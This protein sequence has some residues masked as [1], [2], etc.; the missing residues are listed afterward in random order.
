MGT[1]YIWIGINVDEQ[2]RSFRKRLDS[3]EEELDINKSDVT[4]PFHISLKM[5]FLL[6]EN[7]VDDVVNDIVTYYQSLKSFQLSVKGI[8]CYENIIWIRMQETNQINKISDDLNEML[9]SQFGV[10]LHEYDG[11][12][13]FHSTLFMNDDVGKC[14]RIYEA[15][16]EDYLPETLTAERF[17]LCLSD[18]GEPGNF[19]II[20]EI[21]V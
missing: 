9:L 2:L 17:Q 19:H 4:L 12:H 3:L 7:L 20:R 16:L 21:I 1:K 15:L 11:D 18:T 8:E 6:D 13:V 5:P 10:E 14:R